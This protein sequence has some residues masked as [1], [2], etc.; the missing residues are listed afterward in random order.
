M[1]A[2]SWLGGLL[3]VLLACGAARGA[4]AG[5]GL[6]YATRLGGNSRDG[7]GAIAVDGSGNVWVAGKTGS[8][9]FP[10]TADAWQKEKA[11]GCD[12]FVAK[13]SPS[14]QLLYATYLGGS[15]GGEAN[16]LAVDGSGNVWVAG[17]THSTNFPV[18]ADAW[19]KEKAGGC[20]AFVAKFSPS[21]QLLY[22]TYLGGSDHDYAN[23]LAVDGS[24]HV[25]VAGKTHSTNFPVTADAWQKEYGGDSSSVYGDAFV[26]RFSPSG[27]LRYATYLGG[28]Y[29]GEANALAVDAAGSVWVAGETWSDNFPVTA[30]AWQKNMGG[31]Y[32]AFVAKFSPSGQLLYATYLGGNSADE[33]R[34]LAVDG[35]GTVWVAGLT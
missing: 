24:G 23:A 2:G 6:G 8:T 5:P 34:A 17:R 22:A 16:A 15:Y 4:P 10:V 13:F 29:G 33:A 30:D 19:Q 25:W 7:A 26:A 35:S 20:D 31:E 27:Q 9:N 32:D 1:K 12:A 11:G 14:G 21:G 18:T 28:S 3:C